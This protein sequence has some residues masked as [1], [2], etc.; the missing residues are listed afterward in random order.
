MRWLCPSLRE[1]CEG[2]DCASCKQDAVAYRVV[3]SLGD[4]ETAGGLILPSQ[5]AAGSGGAK[6]VLAASQISGG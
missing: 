5:N 1:P 4:R 2:A 6:L 3:D